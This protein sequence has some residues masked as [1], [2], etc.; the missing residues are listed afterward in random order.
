[1]KSSSLHSHYLVK[2]A[3]ISLWVLAVFWICLY[4]LGLAFAKEGKEFVLLTAPADK[5]SPYKA[6]FIALF[7]G[8]G[9]FMYGIHLMSKGLQR[10]AGNKIKAILSRLTGR[11]IYGLLLGTIVTAIIQSS[12]ATTVMVVGFVNAGLLDFVHSIGI[13]LGANVG[14]TVTTQIVA[15]K[16]DQ[17][18][19]PAIGLGMVMYLFSRS[20]SFRHSG[21]ALLG[22]GLLFLGIA[23]MKNSIPPEAQGLIRRLF[24]LSSGTLSGTLLGL[25]IGTVATAVVQSSSITVSLI[26]ILAM[27]GTVHSL[28]EALPLILGCNIGTCVTALLASV[29]A[30]RE[31]IRV[32][33]A[34]TFFNVFGA[35]FTLVII[36]PF[37]LWAIPALGGDLARQ[38]A[39]V[40]VMIKLVDAVI[41]LPI[42]RPFASLITRLVPEEK[43]VAIDLG[44]PRYLMKEY[45]AEP[46]VGL[47]IALKEILRLGWLCRAAVK[48]SMDGFT[49]N[50]KELIEKGQ[51]YADAAS[52]L[53]KTIMDFLTS[54]SSQD[55]SEEE[56]RQARDLILSLYHFARVINEVRELIHLG[57]IKISKNIPLSSK[58]LNELKK[59]YREVDAAFSEIQTLLPEFAR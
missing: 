54:L 20:S 44:E 37:Y 57:K 23:I 55:L 59:V 58:A 53:Q 2:A 48:A 11:P 29:K 8:I 34:H 33:L 25:L 7:G 6:I 12:S 16:L 46:P 26:V 28:D 9:L 1:M 52:R 10:W 49:Y 30:S 51:T 42:V 3:M 22:F 50:K 32:A 43:S 18:A 5:S 47:A 38:I 4:P 19:L 40:H 17:L 14:T 15:L 56:A 13:I 35:F 24:T 21:A 31:A 45:T 41:F 39:N 27:Q 36:R